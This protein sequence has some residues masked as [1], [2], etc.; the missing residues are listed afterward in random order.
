MHTY[1]RSE[2]IIEVLGCHDKKLRVSVRQSL[3]QDNWKRCKATSCLKQHASSSIR[4]PEIK[5]R[6]ISLYFKNDTCLS[7][8]R[9]S[10][11]NARE[12]FPAFRAQSFNV[13]SH[14]NLSST[15]PLLPIL[16]KHLLSFVSGFCFVLAMKK[17]I[18]DSFSLN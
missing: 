17:I 8:Q 6:Q 12:I 9:G 3:V 18:S 10:L 4:R 13:Y 11:T 1:K 15:K 7:R 14:I 2:D 5:E 16:A